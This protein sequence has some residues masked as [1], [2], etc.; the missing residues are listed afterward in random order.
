MEGFGWALSR[1]SRCNTK[2]PVEASHDILTVVSLKSQVCQDVT[3]CDWLCINQYFN[4]TYCLELPNQ[5]VMETLSDLEDEYTM[6]LHNIG[7][8]HP[9]SMSHPKRT[10]SYCVLTDTS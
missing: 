6:L 7:T 8:V 5:A 3:L 9:T 2:N 10:E 1:G 4:G